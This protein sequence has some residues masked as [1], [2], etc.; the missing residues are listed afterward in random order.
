MNNTI[1]DISSLTSSIIKQS[2]T[3]N[4]NTIYDNIKDSIQQYNILIDNIYSYTNNTTEVYNKDTIE[5]IKDSI[6]KI[7][8]K[9]MNMNK[10]SYDKIVPDT[11]VYD[12][13]SKIYTLYDH[14]KRLLLIDIGNTS[15]HKILEDEFNNTKVEIDNKEQTLTTL[16]NT[17]SGII[18]DIKQMNQQI[19]SLDEQIDKL[20][21]DVSSM[22]LY[23]NRL[24]RLIEEKTLEYNSIR[25]DYEKKK[26]LNDEDMGGLKVK[27]QE[28]SKMK[29]NLKEQ[30]DI[31]EQTAHKNQQLLDDILTTYK[32]H[33]LIEESYSDEL[34][35][36]KILNNYNK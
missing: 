8:Y 27:E 24:H 33:L 3:V 16:K 32:Q 21:L 2:I 4:N 12:E 18:E 14:D 7:Q 22:D 35:K 5:D 36:Q 19:M 11:D 9:Y 25:E 30:N 26:K 20:S 29:T 1:R 15:I 10:I 31:L 13:Y 23:N 6:Y 28:L 34:T 17:N